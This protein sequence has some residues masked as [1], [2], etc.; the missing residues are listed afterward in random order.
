MGW[1]VLCPD[2]QKLARGWWSVLL[3]PLQDRFDLLVAG[4]HLG[5]INFVEFQRL[6]QG[7]DV[8]LP[9][10]ANQRLTNRLHRRMT[11]PITMGGQNIRI[12]LTRHDR[13]DDGHASYAGD[14][15]H[16]MVQLKV[17]LHQRLLHVLICAAA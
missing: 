17:H 12:A 13:P 14:I 1:C 15:G 6:G 11:P 5:L 16:D 4:R 3:Q 10:V 8:L 9:V 2:G 7:E